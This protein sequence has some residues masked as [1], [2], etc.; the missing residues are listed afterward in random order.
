MG[1][2]YTADRKNWPTNTELY[3]N[4]KQIPWS[5]KITKRR[6]SFFGHVC[7]LPEEAPAK[8][9]LKE[10]QCKI[11]KPRGRPRTTFLRQIEKE[12]Q[13]KYLNCIND[14]IDI[15]QNRQVWK[16]RTED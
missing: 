5:E 9:A 4:T 11:K 16:H 8:I 14:A 7:R 13:T 2:R 10:A 6:L 12:L 3:D 15:A 1:Y